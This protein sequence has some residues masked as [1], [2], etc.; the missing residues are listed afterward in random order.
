M[1]ARNQP[2]PPGATPDAYAAQI[3]E[4]TAEQQQALCD[5]TAAYID[6]R[7][8]NAAP[9]PSVLA[10]TDVKWRNEMRDDG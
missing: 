10:Q 3:A 9:A 1:T 5:L 2:R 7:Y 4:L 6:V 8:G